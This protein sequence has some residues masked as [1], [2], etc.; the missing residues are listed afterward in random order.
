M[1]GGHEAARVH[2][3]TLIGGAAAWPLGPHAQ[4]AAPPA[5]KTRISIQRAHAPH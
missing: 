5:I 1:K 4:Q 2:L 3:I